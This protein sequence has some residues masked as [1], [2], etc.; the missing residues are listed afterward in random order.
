VEHM[1]SDHWSLP[2]LWSGVWPGYLGGV[3]QPKREC[4]AIARYRTLACNLPA[5]MKVIFRCLA[6]GKPERMPILRLW[7]RLWSIW[8]VMLLSY[9]LKRSSNIQKRLSFPPQPR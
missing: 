6:R 3:M 5:I 2:V 8:C 9:V 4:T 1:A 7:K